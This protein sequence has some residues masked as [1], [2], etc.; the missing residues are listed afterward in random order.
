[1]KERQIFSIST[2]KEFNMSLE[3]RVEAIA[4]NLEGKVQETVGELT[5]NENQ[6]REGQMKQ[7]QA[8]AMNV[9]E[10]LKD[11]A[12]KIIDKA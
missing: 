3:K 7:V 5:G 8:S 6:K 4:K 2:E 12:K 11:K 10:D 1:M 9:R